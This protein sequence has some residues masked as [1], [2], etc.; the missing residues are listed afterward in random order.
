MLSTTSRSRRLAAGALVL[1]LPLAAVAGCGAE[2]KRTI[3]AELASAQTNLESSKA[4]S[5]TVRLDDTKGAIAKLAAKDGKSAVT[6][7]FLKGSVTFTIDPAGSATMKQLS[8]DKTATTADVKA[9]LKKVNFSVLVR[10]DKADLGELR[11]VE[12]TLFVH[13]NLAEVGRLAEESGVKDFDAQ[14][15]ESAQSMDP[16]LAAALKDVRAGKWIALPIADYLDQLKGLAETFGGM[17]IPTPKPGATFDSQALG[18]DLF[19]AV[20]PYIKVTDANDSSSDRV[21]DVKVQVRPA[22]KAAL[23]VLKAAKDLPFAAALGAFD[24]AEIDKNVTDGTANGTLTLKSGHLTQATLDLESIRLLSTDPGTDS[25]AGGML[26]MD[27]D[28]SAQELKAPD[29]VSSFDLGA[30]V[31]EFLANFDPSGDGSSMAG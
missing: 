24:A 13:V 29:N 7:A 16:R 1:V 3:K 27:L 4:T 15:D 25:A 20:K 19:A 28:D 18:K 17:A 14:L 23:A 9:Q 22:L 10:D 12:G 6:D 21:L 31:K 2:K 30:L 8:E 26:V 11:L 5:L